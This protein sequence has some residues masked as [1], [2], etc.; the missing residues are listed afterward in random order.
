MSEI[1]LPLSS[2]EKTVSCWP[3]FYAAAVK[4]LTPHVWGCRTIAHGARRGCGA[5]R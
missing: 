5:K 4:A 1:P 2:S 3:H